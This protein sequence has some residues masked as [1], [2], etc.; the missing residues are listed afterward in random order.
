M[1][2]I[3]PYLL[4][5]GIA[6]E[7]LEFYRSV[8]GGAIELHTFGDFGRSDGPADAI[9]HGTLVGPVAVY[10]ADAGADED[11]LHM[12][13]MFFSLLGAAAPATLHRWFDALAAAGRV[14]QPLERREWGASDGQVVDQYGVRWLVGYEGESAPA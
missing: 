12:G 5:P 13:G 6:E 14:L 3:T 8:F 4:F 1:T 2:G 11:A 10:G 9:A 7:A